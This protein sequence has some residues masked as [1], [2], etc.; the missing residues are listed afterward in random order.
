MH[1]KVEFTWKPQILWVIQI[2]FRRPIQMKLD[3]NSVVFY[4]VGRKP[5]ISKSSRPHCRLSW[6]A[7]QPASIHPNRSLFTIDSNRSTCKQLWTARETWAT[8]LIVWWTRSAKSQTKLPKLVS[9]SSRWKRVVETK[10]LDIGSLSL[11]CCSRLR[12]WE[13]SRRSASRPRARP[14]FQG[15]PQCWPCEKPQQYRWVSLWTLPTL[16]ETQSSRHW[17]H[18]PFLVNPQ[19]VV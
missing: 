6:S 3:L 12:C 8:W 17:S 4:Q 16:W 19:I 18:T 13:T 2:D 11:R 1:T 9:W 10:W 15:R 14:S 5:K 7:S